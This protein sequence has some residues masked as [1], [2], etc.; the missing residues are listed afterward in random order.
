MSTKIT[1][2]FLKMIKKLLRWALKRFGIVAFKRSSRVYI[3]EDES[4]RIVAN[5]VGRPDPVVID[6]GAHMGDMV[7][8]FGGL[9]PEAQFHCFEPDPML[10]KTLAHKYA[11]NSRVHI[12]QAA[13]GEVPAKAKFNVNISRPTNSLLK[14]SDVLQPDLKKLCELVEQVEVEV[15]TI[16]EYCRANSI[17]CVDVIK[18]DLQG[19]DFLALKGATATLDKARVVLVEVLFKEIYQGCHRFP[20]ILGLMQEAGFDLYTICGLHYGNLSELLWADA[21]FVRHDRM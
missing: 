21:I 16:D 4:Y 18:L 19:Y 15:V 13:L 12:V 1:A 17:D 7:D 11:S 2:E 9:L 20:D 5:L 6:G 14:A 8:S 3:P 10:G